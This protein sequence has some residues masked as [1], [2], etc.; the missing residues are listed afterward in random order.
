MFTRPTNSD[1]VTAWFTA[2][3]RHRNTCFAGQVLT[4]DGVG[5]RTYSSYWATVND[6]PA[7]FAGTGTDINDPVALFDCLFVM[8]NDQDC[9]AK[10]A[11][12]NQSVNQ[13]TVIS[14]MQPNAWFV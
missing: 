1:F 11:Q 7:M 5:R 3:L 12:T 13:T 8:F 4:C 14:L 2:F 9:V 6:P 10:I